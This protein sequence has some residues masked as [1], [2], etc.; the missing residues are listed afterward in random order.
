MSKLGYFLSG[1]LA[2]VVGTV[3]ACI[4]GCFGS[5]SFAKALHYSPTLIAYS[6]KYGYK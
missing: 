4:A 3:V 2:G 1:A 6:K 5:V